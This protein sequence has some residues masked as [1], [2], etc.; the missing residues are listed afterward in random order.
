MSTAELTST[1][2]HN[3]PLPSAGNLAQLVHRLGDIPLE[4]ILTTP[5]PGTATEQDLLRGIDGSI[6]CELV[7]GVL[8]VKAM[9]FTESVVA[10]ILIQ[11]INNFLDQHPLGAC[12]GEQGICKLMPGVVRAPDVSFISREQLAMAKG[13]LT[14]APCAPLLCVEIWSKGNTRR[15]I[16]RKIDEYFQHG[17]RLVWEIFPRKQRAVIY[18]SPTKI[19]ALT[20]AD[21]IDGEDVLPG[22][23]FSLADLF[24]ATDRRLAGFTDAAD[25]DDERLP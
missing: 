22:F 11:W 1:T 3:F 15:E 17:A 5:A 10:S 25:D 24:A 2:P 8:V 13:D 23:R 12:A 19:T 18:H 16:D 14:F 9:G 7:D 20:P 6:W 21:H 4:R